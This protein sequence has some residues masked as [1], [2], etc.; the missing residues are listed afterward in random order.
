M[1]KK[2]D[3]RE[4]D[5][6]ELD[7]LTFDAMRHCG[8]IPPMTIEEVTALEA[9]LPKVE[10]PF[11]PSIPSELLKRVGTADQTDDSTV[12]PLRKVEIETARNLA[13][14]AREGRALSAETERRMAEDKA[15]HL[16]R[17]HDEQ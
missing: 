1:A 9:E 15:N 14:A 16:K 4:L 7:Q 8:M 5:S 3:N 6:A 12:L 17:K 10:L 2:N 11:R 13:R